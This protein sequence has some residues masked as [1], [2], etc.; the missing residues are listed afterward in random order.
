M[1]PPEFVS[2]EP[3]DAQLLDTSPEQVT[4]FPLFTLP[5]LNDDLREILG[6]PNFA[7]AQI[8]DVLRLGGMDI[9]RKAEAEQAAVI[10]WMLVKY[11]EHGASWWTS[12]RAE[13][14]TILDADRPLSRKGGEA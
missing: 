5:P 13:L 2:V 11:S 4:T 12:C 7:C 9:A 6:R 10:Y 1:M 3:C 14:H 8:A